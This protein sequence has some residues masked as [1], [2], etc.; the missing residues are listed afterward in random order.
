MFWKRV[1]IYHLPTSGQSYMAWRNMLKGSKLQLK[2]MEGVLKDSWIKLIHQQRKPVVF[3]SLQCQLRNCV[4]NGGN[5]KPWSAFAS[6]FACTKAH[7]MMNKCAAVPEVGS[8]WQN[9]LAMAINAFG[10]GSCA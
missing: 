3:F 5:K 2:P 7:F 8:Y 10:D 9:V 6:S 4:Q 1:K